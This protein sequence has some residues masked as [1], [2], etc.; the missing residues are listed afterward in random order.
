MHTIEEL[1]SHL[2]L[3]VAAILFAVYMLIWCTFIGVLFMMWV[4]SAFMFVCSSAEYLTGRSINKKIPLLSLL[5]FG[6]TS[7]ILYRITSSLHIS[8]GEH[9]IV[10]YNRYYPR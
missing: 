6:M 4:V 3:P 1:L 10:D 5:V 9:V 8:S 2:P 7:T